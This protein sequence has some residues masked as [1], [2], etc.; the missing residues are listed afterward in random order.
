MKTCT[1]FGQWFV[2]KRAEEHVRKAV[3]QLIEKDR[4]ELFLVGNEGGF[5]KMVQRLLKELEESYPHIRYGLVFAYG[6][7]AEK[8]SHCTNVIFPKGLENIPKKYA[9]AYRNRWMIQRSDCAVVYVNKRFEDSAKF[10][11]IGN[12][13]G[14]KI[15]NAAKNKMPDGI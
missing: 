1:F 15:I 13:Q 3:I 5:N 9:V 11:K 12:T 4:V 14:L 6:Y 8:M 10:K 7:K 2:S